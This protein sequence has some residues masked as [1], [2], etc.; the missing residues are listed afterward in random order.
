FNGGAPA[1]TAAL[2][3]HIN[4]VSSSLPTAV[5]QIN[6]GTLRGLGGAG[7]KR[8]AAAPHVPTYAGSGYPNHSET[9]IG[10]FFSA[11]K[12]DP[13]VAR[14][15]AE[16][17]AAVTAADVQ[18]KLRKIGFDTV[19][20]TPSEATDYFQGEIAKWDTMSRAIGFLTD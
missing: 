7:G 15:N 20:L 1:I 12:P 13:V 6:E 5:A 14:L 2:G 11:T 10:F 17:N 4:L 3:N 18:Q 8:S 16:I 9:W 19:S